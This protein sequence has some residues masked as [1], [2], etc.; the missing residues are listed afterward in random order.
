MINGEYQAQ[1]QAGATKEFC[2]LINAAGTTR[3]D[4]A[5]YLGIKERLF[6]KWQAGESPV[7]KMAL[8]ALKVLVK[9]V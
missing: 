3:R 6:Y 5:D 7:P 4:I 9:E 1:Q 2:R 8:I